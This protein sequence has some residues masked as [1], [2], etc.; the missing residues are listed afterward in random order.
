MSNDI[1]KPNP[2]IDQLGIGKKQVK[3]A[4]KRDTLGQEEFLKI[5]IAQVQSQD[6][7]K[8]QDN[9]EFL[10]QMAQFSTVS[11][12]QEMQQSIDKLNESMVSNQ[13]LQASS[14]VG[15]FV[16]VP[17][18]KGFLPQ[19]EGERFFGGVELP[20]TA[21]DIQVQIRNNMGV[22]IRNISLGSEPEGLARFAWD[23]KDDQGQD[24]PSGD[25]TI[26][27]TGN[28]AG[29]QEAF[30]TNFVAPVDS[31]TLGRNGEGMKLNV[32]GLG[33]MTMDQVKEIL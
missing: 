9:G 25:Y 26:T 28:I 22:P 33:S 6:P 3:E 29:K 20:E 27:A 4:E 32:A 21:T 30:T 11:G 18:D 24:M 12:L 2:L 16:M 7:M 13:A 10:G 23:G 19:G 31:V 14:L 15:R 1:S 17:A 8:P 5:L